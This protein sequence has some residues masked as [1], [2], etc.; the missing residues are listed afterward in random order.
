MCA[1]PKID[2]VAET[3]SHYEVAPFLEGGEPRIAY[4][5]ERLRSIVGASRPGMSSALEVGCGSGELT[6]ALMDLGYDAVAM[7]LTRRACLRARDR[8]ISAVQ[9]NA[10]ALP[11]RSRSVDLVIAIG[12]LHHTPDWVTAL[13]APWQIGEIDAIRRATTAGRPLAD[14]QFLKFLEEHL[15]YHPAPGRTGRPRLPLV[16]AASGGT[17]K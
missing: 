14:S 6:R 17:S 4:R 3:R 15:G 12:V 16:R 5:R 11:M 8:E 9:G 7:D 2:R 13:N 10:L 1:V